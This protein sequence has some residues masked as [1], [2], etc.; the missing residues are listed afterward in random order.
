MHSDL[1]IDKANNLSKAISHWGADANLIDDINKSIEKANLRRFNPQSEYN[2]I[3]VYNRVLRTA[4][5]YCYRHL[6]T[7]RG[8]RPR[9]NEY[10][11]EWQ[12]KVSP[13][14]PAE[15]HKV[16]KRIEL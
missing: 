9:E 11:K 5:D 3:D 6:K 4:E 13:S 7:S 16:K 10:N 15:G 1:R 12:S 14:I 8:H 2:I